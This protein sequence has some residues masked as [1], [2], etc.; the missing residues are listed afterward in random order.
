MI[1]SVRSFNLDS[2][3]LLK[4]LIFSTKRKKNSQIIMRRIQ[5]QLISKNSPPRLIIG[6]HQFS[7]HIS[8][9]T[10]FNLKLDNL[11]TIFADCTKI[12]KRPD[13]NFLEFSGEE[14][15]SKK[16]RA[17]CCHADKEFTRTYIYALNILR[18]NKS[19][20]LDTFWDER[21]AHSTVPS[22]FN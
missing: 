7:T 14:R 18:W 5:S 2:A 22:I 16:W 13:L 1:T 12:K 4:G 10:A 3:K 9:L 21:L 15:L 6:H 20:E 11:M 17:F 19:F 8:I